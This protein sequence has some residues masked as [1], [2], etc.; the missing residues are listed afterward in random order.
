LFK[1]PQPVSSYFSLDTIMSTNDAYA[2]LLV[3]DSIPDIEATTQ[4]FE[5]TLN[6]H[7]TKRRKLNEEEEVTFFFSPVSIFYRTIENIKNG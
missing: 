3:D 5:K 6:S 1:N 2:S 7:L 4:K